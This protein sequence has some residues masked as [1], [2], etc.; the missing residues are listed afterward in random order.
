M[1]EILDRIAQMEGKVQQFSESSHWEKFIQHMIQKNMICFAHASQLLKQ[2][3]M[4]Q[5]LDL[6]MQGLRECAGGCRE[7]EEQSH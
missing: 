3:R 7:F 4:L 1:H 5:E 6:R 2:T